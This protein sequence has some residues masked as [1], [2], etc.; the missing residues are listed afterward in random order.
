MYWKAISDEENKSLTDDELKQKI[1]NMSFTKV[2][3]KSD[4]FIMFNDDGKFQR[5]CN[6][7]EANSYYHDKLHLL[8]GTKCG[9]EC[10]ANQSNPIALY[11]HV[12]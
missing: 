8:K 5:F 7:E 12:F 10:R 3:E 2:F 6:L 9:F 11:C 4:S 1:I